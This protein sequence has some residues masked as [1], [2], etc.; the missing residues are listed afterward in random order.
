MVV[1][2][3]CSRNN[4]D[5]L[6]PRIRDSRRMPQVY[7]TWQTQSF[8]CHVRALGKTAFEFR[9]ELSAEVGKG[10][11]RTNS[12]HN[13]ETWRNGSES[14]EYHWYYV[15]CVDVKAIGAVVCVKMSSSSSS[16]HYVR[17]SGIAITWRSCQ[18]INQIV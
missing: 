16:S 7:C 6:D 18:D 4:L 17:S 12:P 15:I 11:P 10:Y 13:C 2:I 8:L 9:C 5:N 1:E 14:N 3:D